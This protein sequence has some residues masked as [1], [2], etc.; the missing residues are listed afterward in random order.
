MIVIFYLYINKKLI[1]G[2]I[3]KFDNYIKEEITEGPEIT[4]Q[5]FVTSERPNVIPAPQSTKGLNRETSETNV[6]DIMKKS[7]E[8]Y[9]YIDVKGDELSKIISE[10]IEP[11][12]EEHKW[13]EAKKAVRDFYRP[14]R[15]ND[16]SEGLGDVIFIEYDLI[17]ARI[18]RLKRE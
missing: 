13:D 8:Y 9:E 17:L 14:S 11:L 5:K 1:M 3:K 2:D 4:N 10:Q 18:N 15:F 16:G 7:L 6:S 12:L